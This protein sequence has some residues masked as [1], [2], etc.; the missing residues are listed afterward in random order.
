M[1]SRFGSF[2]QSVNKSEES[3]LNSHDFFE[4]I[5]EGDIEKCNKII[6]ETDIK[7]WEL[8]D[9]KS[10]TVL[11]Y[12]VFQNNYELT[13]L[14]L[15]ET[16]KGFGINSL[17]KMPNYINSKNKDGIT[18]LHYSVIKGNIKIF[19]LLKKY[20]GNLD[21]VTNTGKNI[22]HLAAESN[23][24]TMMI[25][26]FLN[27][28]REV[29]SVDESGSTPLHWACYYQAEECVNY[30][31]N[32]PNVDIN[33]QDRDRITPLNIAVSN[34]KV[35]LV[36]L[37]LRKGADK[38]IKGRNN[39]LPIDIANK[40]NFYHIIDV[41]N[42]ENNNI[43]S[44]ETPNMQIQL[45]GHYKRLILALLIVCE[46]IIIIFV[47]PF[48]D[49]LIFYVINLFLFILTILAYIL[50]SCIEPGYQKNKALV[51]ECR[52]E[53]NYKCW[54]KLV[55]DGDDL[56]KYCPVCYVIRSNDIKHCFICNKCVKDISHHCFW[57]NKCIGRKNKP[58]YITFLLITFLFCVYTIFICT[59][60]LFDTVN[61][62]FASLL[63]TWFYLGIDRGF[64][65]LGATLVSLVAMIF[66]YPLFFLFM[67]EMFKL[68]GLLG[69]KNKDIEN[70][71][72]D[73][74]PKIN[75]EININ[76]DNNDNNNLELKNK[77][78]DIIVNDNIEQNEEND[79][80]EN[81]N[82]F[83]L[84]NEKEDKDDEEN[85][86]ENQNLIVE[87]KNNEN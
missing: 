44:N 57:F 14:V 27:E 39:Q 70:L 4:A 34:N 23:Q 79:N 85:E 19:D 75:K 74:G 6:S 8:A 1:F 72:I 28:G 66:S 49:N 61:I 76:I 3:E 60:L 87:N 10:N 82:K 64:R 53:D 48:L 2:K 83:P 36:K 26:L 21:T 33:A 20:G 42:S 18:S 35:N 71:I 62:P 25:Y 32:I 69:K 67:I 5:K 24:P 15:E 65:V 45:S 86:N 17:K 81:N 68:C 9:E 55:E 38:N 59:Y 12:S 16:K 29:T 31:L 7:I 43:C 52:G 47:L 80:D 40:K 50:I 63:P 54:K 56:R 58:Y 46:I 73:N 22:M 11:H 41:L 13:L 77:E 37:L 84:I 51:Q 78:N 30:L